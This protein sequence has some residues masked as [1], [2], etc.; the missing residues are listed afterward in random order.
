MRHRLATGI[1]AVVLTMMCWTM[2][3]SASDE[4]TPRGSRRMAPGF[5]LND[6]VGVPVKLS[7]YKGRVVLLNFWATWCHGCKTEIPWYVEFSNK[8]K[9]SGLVVIGVSMDDDGWKSVKPFV[10]EKKLNY[11]IVIGNEALASKYGALD[12]MPVSVLI[13]RDGKIADSHA[14]VVEKDNWE[15]KIEKLLQETPQPTSR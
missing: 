14:G 9:D 7:D 5:S 8:Y 13:D 10:E 4:I 11:P 12:N 15:E 1:A 2:L 3:V 6:D